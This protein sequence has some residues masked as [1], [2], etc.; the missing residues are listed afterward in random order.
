M[1]SL[2]TEI[3]GQFQSSRHAMIERQLRLRGIFDPRV[4]AAMAAVPRELFVPPRLIDEAY[5][6]RDLPLVAGRTLPRPYIAAVMIEALELGPEDRVLEIGTGC[7]YAAAVMSQVAGH[8]VTTERLELLAIAARER[9]AVLGFG[10]IEVRHGDG[11]RGVDDGAPY[12]AIVM[13]EIGRSVPQPLLDQLAI[14]G[15]L[16]IPIE[17]DG[18]QPLVRIRR[19]DERQYAMSD[20]GVQMCGRHDEIPDLD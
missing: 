3:D 10:G 8:V 9:L 15:R 1:T 7:G 14:G 2:R 19:H 16:V 12:S 13:N 11:R 4:L 5:V 6:D 17:R 20:L 18:Q